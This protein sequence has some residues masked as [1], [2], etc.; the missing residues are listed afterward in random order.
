ML[1]L[2]S[3]T[4]LDKIKIAWEHK[5]EVVG[6]DVLVCCGSK[7]QFNVVSLQ[8]LQ[9]YTWAMIINGTWKLWSRVVISIW[10]FLWT[11]LK[12]CWSITMLF[13]K[14]SSCCR[15][16]HT[17]NSIVDSLQSLEMGT[18][19]VSFQVL[20]K[21]WHTTFVTLAETAV[22]WTWNSVKLGISTIPYVFTFYCTFCGILWNSHC[23]NSKSLTSVTILNQ[24]FYN[25]QVD[26]MD[27]LGGI[28]EFS[29]LV[30]LEQRLKHL[31]ITSQHSFSLINYKQQLF[32]LFHIYLNIIYSLKWLKYNNFPLLLVAF[33]AIFFFFFC[34]LKWNTI[35]THQKSLN[36]VTHSL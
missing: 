33:I 21:W 32:H 29:S 9:C 2:Q 24:F 8:C 11:R 5:L 25:V 34:F 14:A 20:N 30:T 12:T 19:L 6:P 22:A 23:F 31:L 4:F 27:R 28:I 26:G 18:I 17:F 10:Q 16:N 3:K 36:G 7:S 13:T 1:L 15:Q 35:L